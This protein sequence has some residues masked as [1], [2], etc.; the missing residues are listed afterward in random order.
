MGG[1]QLIGTAFGSSKLESALCTDYQ[2]LL[3][4]I[5]F[6][7]YKTVFSN[8]MQSTNSFHRTTEHKKS[9][10]KALVNTDQFLVSWWVVVHILC[11]VYAERDQS[12]APASCQPAD[13]TTDEPGE[14]PSAVLNVSWDLLSAAVSH[15][16]RGVSETNS[17]LLNNNYSCCWLIN[18]CVHVR[19]NECK[20]QPNYITVKMQFTL[21]VT[22]CVQL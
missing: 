1:A 6:S 18:Q 7:M 10:L 14:C 8:A 22:C 16:H 17:W 15:Y 19:K 13:E 11:L 3:W 5:Y 20:W 12:Y 2:G 4:N 21:C 9:P